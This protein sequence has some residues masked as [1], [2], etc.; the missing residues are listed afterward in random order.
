MNR[1]TLIKILIALTIISFVF[2]QFFFLKSTYDANKEDL[3]NQINASLELTKEEVVKDRV[4]RKFAM[5]LQDLNDTNLVRIDYELNNGVKPKVTVRD[6]KSDDILM[7]Y[8]FMRT[9]DPDSINELTLF[10]RTFGKVEN[11]EDDNLRSS[12]T[13]GGIIN[14]RKEAYEDTLSINQELLDSLLLENLSKFD[15]EVAFETLYLPADSVFNGENQMMSDPIVLDDF[16]GKKNVVVKISNPF[17]FVVQRSLFVVSA[18]IAALM[19]LLVSFGF[20]LRTISKQNYLAQIKDDFIDNITHELLTPISTLKV[21]LESLERNQK[22][23]NG[24]GSID[25]IQIAKN[26]SD[27]IAGIVQNV[28][29]VSLHNP[30]H[31]TVRLE[32]VELGFLLKSIVHYYH[33]QADDT[34]NIQLIDLGIQ[35][36]MA[37]EQ[38]LKN[39][40]HN[41]IDNAIKY[42]NKDKIEVKLGVEIGEKVKV[43]VQDNGRGVSDKEREKIFEKFHRVSQ[44]GLHEVKGMGIGLYYSKMIILKMG[45]DLKLEKSDA[46]GSTFTITLNK[47]IGG[48]HV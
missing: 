11:F 6:A 39:V 41:L 24:V 42:A 25:Y 33:T 20:M 44:N 22:M 17:W 32:D 47:C 43:L 30:G 13:L 48:S 29:Q 1:I 38:H 21:S 15:V 27:R 31:L 8:N 3:L 26:E 12:F 10:N 2:I 34:Q 46:E 40:L 4:K 37:D 14:Q 9:F 23:S 5:Q 36:V 7:I 16:D 28:L 18:S 35:W 45:G 19:L